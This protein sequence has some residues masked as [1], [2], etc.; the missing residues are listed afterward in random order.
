[1]EDNLIFLHGSKQHT[2][3][4]NLIHIA[5]NMYLLKEFGSQIESLKVPSFSNIF[6]FVGYMLEL[7]TIL[8]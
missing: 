6:R 5:F 1:M 2:Y 7:I 8:G 3:I 4:F